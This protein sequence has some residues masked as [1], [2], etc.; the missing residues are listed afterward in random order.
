MS[1]IAILQQR[2]VDPTHRI[3]SII[4]RVNQLTGTMNADATTHFRSLPLARREVTTAVIAVHT[5]ALIK[6][7]NMAALSEGEK[8]LKNTTAVH[9]TNSATVTKDMATHSDTALHFVSFPL[10]VSR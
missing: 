7:V 8:G 3:H 5:D 2:Q 6:G 10:R 9:R 4:N 1:A